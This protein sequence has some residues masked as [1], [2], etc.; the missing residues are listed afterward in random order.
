LER[1]F[2]LLDGDAG[3]F[4]VAFP[5]CPGCTAMG[6]DENEAYEHAIAALSEWIHDAR[7]DGA[8]PAPRTIDALRRDP[9]VRVA[10]AEGRRFSPFLSSSRRGVPMADAGKVFGARRTSRGRRPSSN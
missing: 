6:V 3:A 10:L 2:A 4:G 1:Y 5:D 8:A 7:A 9:E